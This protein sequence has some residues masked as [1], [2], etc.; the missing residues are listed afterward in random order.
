MKLECQN[1]ADHLIDIVEN[2]IPESQNKAIQEHLTDCPQCRRLIQNFAH[3]WKELTPAEKMVPSESFWPELVA[4][5]KASEK[6]VPLRERIILGLRH[7]LRPAAVSLI[8]IIC[9]F[10]G[11]RL[12]DI[13]RMETAQ[14]DISYFEQFAQDFQD[15]PEGSVS[16]FY[17]RY[18]NQE[19]EEVP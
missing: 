7:S 1:I 2:N 9:A 14:S 19:Q 6:P 5:I 8:L 11:Y 13:P 16:D 18:L 15:F 12:G 10:F 4:R 3:V 17:M